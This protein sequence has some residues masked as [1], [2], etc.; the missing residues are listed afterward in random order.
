MRSAVFQRFP[1]GT[2]IMNS[3]VRLLRANNLFETYLR[4]HQFTFCGRVPGSSCGPAAPGPCERTSRSGTNEV[5]DSKGLCEP[6][7]TKRGLWQPREYMLI[8]LAL[9]SRIFSGEIIANNP[10]LSC[11]RQCYNN[12][13]TLLVVL[14]LFS[15]NKIAQNK[16]TSTKTKFTKHGSP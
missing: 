16:Q 2:V 8:C 15:W 6:H 10:N 4:V 9:Q 13:W 5:R 12:F 3:C 7:R 11:S 14:K 1:K